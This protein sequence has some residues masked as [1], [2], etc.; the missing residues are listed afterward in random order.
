MEMRNE[1]VGRRGWSMVVGD[2]LCRAELTARILLQVFSYQWVS[3]F[4][5]RLF[6]LSISSVLHGGVFVRKQGIEV[7]VLVLS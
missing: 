5:C 2:W 7:Y 1:V 3:L 4:P 6:K